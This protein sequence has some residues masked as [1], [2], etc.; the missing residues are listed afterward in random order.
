MSVLFIFYYILLFCILYR[1]VINWCAFHFLY[2]CNKL[3]HFHPENVVCCKKQAAGS[4][5]TVLKSRG[6]CVFCCY[7]LILYYNP[8]TLAINALCL[9]VTP[10]S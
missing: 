1:N 8:D 2:K 3:V 7:I 5:R 4:L 10:S 9:S 6:F